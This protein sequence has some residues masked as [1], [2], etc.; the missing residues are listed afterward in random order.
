MKKFN[1]FSTYT[2]ILLLIIL[3]SVAFILLFVALR[4]YTIQQE[5]EVF[6]SSLEQFNNEVKSL[7]IL[8]SES[9]ISTII[10]VTYWD[11]LVK[12][13]SVRNMKW[14]NETITSTISMYKVDY[15][16]VYDLQGNYITNAATD[17]IP[18][19]DFVP[20][21][22]FKVLH[23]KKL[24]NFYLKLPESGVV[25]VFAATIH[26]SSDP[27]K[28]KTKPAGYF[29]MARVLD[30]SYFKNL[31]KI[32][33]S[34]IGITGDDSNLKPITKDS[35]LVTSN[36]ND[37]NKETVAK[38]LF[39]RHFTV[40]FDST[41]RILN[42]VIVAFIIAFVSFL[43]YLRKWIFSP[44]GLVT[45][46]LESGS[47]KAINKL[48]VT[49]GEFGY[50]GNLFE[51]NASQQK[52]LKIAKNKAE[53]SDKLKTSFLTNLSHEIRT[54]MNAIIG[55]ADLLKMESLDRKER[56]NYLNVINQ[57]GENLVLIIDDL[58]EMSKIDANQITPNVSS[59]NLES[60]LKDLCK[61]I[62]ITIPKDK[63][64]EFRFI[65]SKNR[66]SQ[67][68]F[69]DEV[70]LKQ[71][72]TNLITNAIKFTDSGFVSFGYDVNYEDKKIEFKIQD[73]GLGIDE[74]YHKIIFDRFR[75]V[76]GDYSIKV[77]G[78]GLGLA[79][80]KAYV[81]MLG[82]E[83]T[84]EESNLGKGSIFSFTI[85][86]EIDEEIK[87]PTKKPLINDQTNYEGSGIILIAEDDNLNYLLFEKIMK[88]KNY[89]ILRAKNGLEAVEICKQNNEINLVLMDIKMPILSGYEAVLQIRKFKPMLPI[90]AQT[91]YSSSDEVEK[92]MVSGFTDYIAKP[93]V[94]EK[95]FGLLTKYLS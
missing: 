31:E 75:R 26:P 84:L 5:K 15:L 36:L 62:Q 22:L 14:F 58:I 83:I 85:P 95:L 50:I 12:F 35:I 65:K 93:L 4:F 74:N 51:E 90:I 80:S 46:V 7:L 82:G 1:N 25:E 88:L 19:I 60:C 78:L 17:K 72:I 16:G 47:K 61:S 42:I 2:K 8:N 44:L 6:N 92:I 48:K 86:L 34:K 27:L 76:E 91:A 87:E 68:I 59:I 32:S 43:F 67:N 21:A 37:W 18:E 77:G 20:K 79:I 28:I 53:E 9:H 52:Q 70:K 41:K 10:D 11:E 73:S 3:S 23:E 33:S 45:K 24:M 71:I 49:P 69:T 56:L 38:L 55:F 30:D 81:E 29:F 64:I 13:I 63:S 39:K 54:P 94:K 40:S 66:L 89:K 57:S